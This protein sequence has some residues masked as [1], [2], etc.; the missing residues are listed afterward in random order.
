MDELWNVVAAAHRRYCYRLA[1]TSHVAEIR[2]RVS[3]HVF[4]HRVGDGGHTRTGRDRPH[5]IGQKLRAPDTR[6]FTRL[7][8]GRVGW[9]CEA[10]ARRRRV[11][12]V[13]SRHSTGHSRLVTVVTDVNYLTL[14]VADT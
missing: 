4:V 13:A 9:S 12:R 14:Y 5:Q 8:T 1:T 7:E 3:L 2:V 11:S 6:Y 10:S